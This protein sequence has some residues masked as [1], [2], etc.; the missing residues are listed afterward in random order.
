MAVTQNYLQALNET[1]EHHFFRPSLKYL[2]LDF[3]PYVPESLLTKDELAILLNYGASKLNPYEF[4][5]T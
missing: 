3:D 5:P 1:K 2:K 4:Y